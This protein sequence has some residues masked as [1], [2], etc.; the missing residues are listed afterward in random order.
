MTPT[1]TVKLRSVCSVTWI[2]QALASLK[3]A[4]SPTGRC[5]SLRTKADA[6]VQ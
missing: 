5:R 3:P 2:T 6:L 4:G 1:P